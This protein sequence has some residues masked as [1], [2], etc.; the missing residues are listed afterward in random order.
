LY[1]HFN[2]QL[3]EIKGTN[4]IQSGKQI[5]PENVLGKVIKL[6]LF[7]WRAELPRMVR[8][9]NTKGDSITVPLTS[10]LTGSE[11]AV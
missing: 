9:G 4:A 8:P 7:V 6:Y 10:C 3:E 11:S 1:E 5:Q 2:E